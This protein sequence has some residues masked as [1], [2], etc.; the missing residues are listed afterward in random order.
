MTVPAKGARSRLEHGVGGASGSGP[1]M[2]VRVAGRDLKARVKYV[3]P[4]P[5]T[6]IS[7]LG[8]EEQRVSVVG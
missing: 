7:P 3:E 8:V 4:A 6:R 1:L 2:L 5:F